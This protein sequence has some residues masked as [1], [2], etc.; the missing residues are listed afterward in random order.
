MAILYFDLKCTADKDKKYHF[1]LCLTLSLNFC[2]SAFLCMSYYSLSLS[3]LSFSLIF[4]FYYSLDFLGFHGGSLASLKSIFSLVFLYMYKRQHIFFFL[5]LFWYKESISGLCN[6]Q[7]G[8]CALSYV[9]HQHTFSNLRYLSFE[10]TTV[11]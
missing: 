9:P 4:V 5:F 7:A 10:N 6:C 8:T 2:L 11:R 1:N 3:S